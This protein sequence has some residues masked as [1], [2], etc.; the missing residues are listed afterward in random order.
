MCVNSDESVFISLIREEMKVIWWR[1]GTI[2]PDSL[3]VSL[4]S[5][6]PLNSLYCFLFYVTDLMLEHIL[7]FLKVTV[8]LMGHN[9]QVF[10]IL[11]MT[12]LITRL[13]WLGG[14]T[15][16]QQN[17]EKKQ[18]QG[19]GV[20]LIFECFPEERKDKG[21]NWVNSSDC[22]WQMEMK[23]VQVIAHDLFPRL[24]EKLLLRSL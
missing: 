18:S 20:G 19:Q 3:C 5:C 4:L 10:L 12:K 13:W 24:A 15:V 9:R 6:M 17:L 8:N 2:R 7:K 11:A 1:T 14:K 22:I 21:K 16:C 23:W